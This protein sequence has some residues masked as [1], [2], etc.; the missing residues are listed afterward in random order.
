MASKR[1]SY[2]DDDSTKDLSV[3]STKR[4]RHDD[5]NREQQ[6]HPLYREGRSEPFRVLNV[7]GKAYQK[8][9]R[10][11]M[12][13]ELWRL[14]GIRKDGKLQEKLAA[15]GIISVKDFLQLYKTNEASLREVKMILYFCS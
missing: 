10:P 15:H 4:I 1:T 8:H 5:D 9:D 2:D 13:D 14:R 7:R 12:N 6:Q 11:S 3:S